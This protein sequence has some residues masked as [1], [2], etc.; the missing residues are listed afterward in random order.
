M[1]DNYLQVY[2][3]ENNRRRQFPNF[4]IFNSYVGTLLSSYIEHEIILVEKKELDIITL[5]VPMGYNVG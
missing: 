3:I 4:N 5:G 1:I 2:Y